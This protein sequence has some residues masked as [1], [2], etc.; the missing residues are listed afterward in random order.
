MNAHE[1]YKKFISEWAN[2][3]SKI[4]E[5]KSY[6]NWEDEQAVFFTEL[7]NLFNVHD[8]INIWYAPQRSWYKPEM[9]DVI[10]DMIKNPDNYDFIP[11][12]YTGEFDWDHENKKFVKKK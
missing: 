8:S 11:N 6:V 12:F 9:M 2:T 1:K 7:D 10:V 3:Y 5:E 4:C